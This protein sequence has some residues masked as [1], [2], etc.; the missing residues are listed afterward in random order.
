[1]RKEEE[2]RRVMGQ[3]P[4]YRVAAFRLLEKKEKE[5]EKDRASKRNA[6]ERRSNSNS[7]AQFE[8]NETAKERWNG[9]TLTFIR[10]QPVRLHYYGDVLDQ[11]IVRF[12]FQVACHSCRKIRGISFSVSDT[13]CRPFSLTIMAGPRISAVP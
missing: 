3:I 10:M 11:F 5:K 8:D 4:V 2:K 12:I 9:T 6:D 7:A 13:V 1:M